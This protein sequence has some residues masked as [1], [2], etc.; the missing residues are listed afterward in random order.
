MFYQ[1]QQQIDLVTHTLGT[2]I[3]FFLDNIKKE[4]INGGIR[5][6]RQG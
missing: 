5:N 2:F 6:V 4:S 1:L 3:G